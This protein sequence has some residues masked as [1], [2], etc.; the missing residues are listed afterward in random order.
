MPIMTKKGVPLWKTRYESQSKY[1]NN[2]TVRIGLK[3]NKNTDADILESLESKP[4]KQGFIKEA[5]R[6]YLANKK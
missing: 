1:D 3:L 2:N 5:I 4:S 6:F